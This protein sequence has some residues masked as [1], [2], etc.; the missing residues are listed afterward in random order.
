[1]TKKPLSNVDL[2]WLRMDD[3]TN[4]MTITGIIILG[5]PLDAERF[6]ATLENSFLSFRRFRQRVIWPR[7]PWRRPYWQDDPHFDLGAHFQK[8]ILQ[9]PGD[10]E[11]L[12]DLI[13]ELMSMP[14]DPM[15]PLW[16]FY[17]VE[18]YGNGSALICRLHHA[19]ADGLALV[20][21]LLSMTNDSPD[22]PTPAPRWGE[23]EEVSWVPLEERVSQARKSVR[24]TLVRTGDLLQQGVDVLGDPERTREYMRL[25]ADL[26]AATGRLVLRWPD[27]QTLFK[28]PLGVKKRA[29]WSVPM[30]LEEVK[31][32]GRT[33]GGTVN[34]VLL[35]ML[36]GALRRYILSQ[37]EPADH[38][39]IRS[40]VPV[41]LR[42]VDLDDELGNQFGLVFLGL[43][44]GVADP[45]RRLYRLKHNM[46]GLKSSSEAVAAFGILGLFGTLP[47]R[48]QDLGVS[49]FDTKGT[50][51]MTNVP[52]PRQQLYLA[53]APIEMM[54]AWVPQ[55]GRIGLGVSI[56]SYCGKVFL[57]VATDAG[58]VPDPESILG[59]FYDEFEA[60]KSLAGETLQERSEIVAPMLS[61]LDETLRALDDMLEGK[62]TSAGTGPDRCKALTK[63]GRRC[64]NAPLPGGDYCRVH[65]GKDE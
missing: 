52:G 35:T 49:I 16:E 65:Q 37:G 26:A 62:H 43:P 59:F 4:L 30:P 38:L 42:P 5:A 6:K 27:P 51:V 20:H 24:E 32:I 22:A 9:P 34:D 40:V 31:H 54:M 14:L 64:R 48:L 60:M 15:R 41:N 28:G 39:S 23:E 63:S 58:L 33:F 2:A 44:I 18:E 10:Q 8:I 11:S 61:R 57:G 19:I 21:V 25:G 17:L 1:M 3:P 46:D 50:A 53:G 47:P 7:Q 45:L 29:T 36:S 55:S 12:Q 56:V 13:S